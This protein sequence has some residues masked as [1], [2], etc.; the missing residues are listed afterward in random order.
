MRFAAFASLAFLVAVAGLGACSKGDQ[1]QASGDLNH[2]GQSAHEALAKVENNPGVKKAETSMRKFAADAKRDIRKMGA[3]AKDA[4]QKFASNAR[5]S[6]HN[7]TQD[8]RS[9]ERSNG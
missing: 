4:T 5:H 7:V 1:T 9:R 8:H 2:A 3:Q 6:A